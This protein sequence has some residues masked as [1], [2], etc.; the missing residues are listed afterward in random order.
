MTF[1]IP[2][3]VYSEDVILS[4]AKVKISYIKPSYLGL[5]VT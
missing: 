1:A 4:Q 5:N 2:F 3:N